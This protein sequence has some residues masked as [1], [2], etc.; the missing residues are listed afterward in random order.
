MR[1]KLNLPKF[2]DNSNILL[3]QSLFIVLITMSGTSLAWESKFYNPNPEPDDVILPMPCGGEMAFRK[4]SVPGAK[5]MEDYPINLGGTDEEWGHVENMRADYIAGSFTEKNSRYY[6]IGK[7]EIN[8]LQYAAVMN[9]ECPKASMKGRLPQNKVN[10]FESIAFT[11]QYN[12]WLLKNAKDKLPSNDGTPGFVRLPTETEWEYAARGGVAVPTSTFQERLFPM[13]EDIKQYVWLAGTQSANG[14]VKLTGLLNPNPLKIYDILGNVDEIV[15]NPFRLNKLTREHGQAGSFVVRGGNFMTGEAAVRTSMR[16][17]VP[18]YINEGLRKSKTTGFRVVVGSALLTSLA[19]IEDYRV[20]WRG[21]GK[22]IASSSIPA[23]IGERSLDN[24]VDELE[25]LTKAVSDA[26]M[27]KRLQNLTQV[28]RGSIEAKS[29]QTNRAANS[30]LRLGYFLCKGLR[31]DAAALRPV[32][33]RYESSCEE[34]VTNEGYCKLAAK[35]IRSSEAII[36]KNLDYYADTIPQTA[37]DY[38]DITLNKQSN[39]LTAILEERKLDSIIEYLDVYRKHLSQFAANG[40]IKKNGW[41]EDCI[42]IGRV[43]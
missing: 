28:L 24:P 8:Q 32:K 29:E 17:E 16:E 13:E 35:R 6:L 26:N 37:L 43:N 21:L 40:M 23:R 2:F 9:D 14:K 12:L 19:T 3:L 7:Y 36:T 1:L 39:I 41:F 42:S 20:A 38:S 22:D 25:A 31:D 4:V 18:Y 33:E 15:L 5:P 10:W 11:N 30:A 27:K 34:K